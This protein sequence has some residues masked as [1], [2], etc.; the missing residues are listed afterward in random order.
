MS[1]LTN[2]HARAVKDLTTPTELPVDTDA[3][4]QVKLVAGNFPAEY[5]G[6]EAMTVGMIKDLAAQ[7]REE[8]LEAVNLKI[9]NEEIRAKEV[10]AAL[11]KD[12]ANKASTLEG[13]GITNAYNQGQIDSKV[14]D[15][16]NKK[17]N[18]I[19]VNTAI[20]NLSTTANKYYSTLA[21]ANADIANIALNQSVTIGEAENSGLWYKASADATSLT[22]SPY[23]P[24]TQSQK[25]AKENTKELISQIVTSGGG[26]SNL[27]EFRDSADDLVV[28]MK[29]NG[30]IITPEADLY[31][32][33]EKSNTLFIHKDQIR[34]TSKT[35]ERS[36]AENLY[37]FQ[38]SEGSDAVSITKEANIQF[39]GGVTLT[40]TA[41]NTAEDTRNIYP[42]ESA[43]DAYVALNLQRLLLSNVSNLT[44][45][46]GSFKQKFTIKN[47]N[48]FLNLKITQTPAISIDT[49]YIAKDLMPYSSQVVHPYICEFTKTVH[50]WKYILAIT[51]FHNTHDLMENP[52]IYGSNDL[53]SFELLQG[54]EQPIAIAKPLDQYNYNSDPCAVF[55]HQ[56][57]E[58][59]CLYRN[60]VLTLDNTS[61]EYSTLHTRRTKDFINWSDVKDIDIDNGD[62][63]PTL[64]FDTTKNK[65]LMFSGYGGFCVRESER[66]EGPWSE[67]VFIATPFIPWHQEVKFCGNHFVGI[68]NDLERRADDG[69]G[70]ISFG[71]STDGLN[72]SFSESIFTGSFIGPY[73]PSIS[74]EFVD[75]NHIRFNIVW[76]SSDRNT[77][78]S[79]RWRLYT[80]K[81]ST[82]EVI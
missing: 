23:D 69:E 43:D 6:N 60:S 82:I 50:G 8:E 35:L 73:K 12:K 26:L 59:V 54:F 55:D 1:E 31:N 18:K 49:P 72:W 10:E 30:N 61:V 9:A 46:V 16:E 79:D 70:N 19:E 80:A 5:V 37:D 41:L 29:S 4:D 25:L 42:K 28:V 13:Y 48:D 66:I 24:L 47:P 14:V 27:Y 38:D 67:P 32:I 2:I 20:S 17:A 21:A 52:C 33:A 51:P 34:A 53:E 56:T 22:K 76:T 58:F 68:F 75:E 78:F 45:F 11:I 65:W 44:P 64:V 71:I 36:L 81:T 3:L 74:H 63:S 7:G 57:G 40:R 77:S 62:V 39:N 15:L